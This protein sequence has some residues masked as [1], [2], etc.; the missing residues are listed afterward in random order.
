MSKSGISIRCKDD[1][2]RTCFTD[3]VKWESRFV[4]SFASIESQLF[5]ND[6]TPNLP[7]TEEENG[8]TSNCLVDRTIGSLFSTVIVALLCMMPSTLQGQVIINGTVTDAIGTGISGVDFDLAPVAG[9][10]SL[11]LSGDVSGING[12]FSITIL[13]GAGHSP[14]NPGMY[15]LQ[16]NPPPGFLSRTESVNLAIPITGGN[17]ALGQF[18]LGSGWVISGQLVDSF[19]VGIP[20]IDIDIQPDSGGATTPDISGD[21]SG[22]G[23][24]FSVTMQSLTSEYN[25][26]FFPPSPATTPT[27]CVGT[28][29]PTAN[30][31]CAFGVLPLQLPV[32]LISGSTNLGQ[33][34]L[35]NAA[36]VTAR[37][38]DSL[39][40]PIVGIDT[41]ALDAQGVTLFLNEDDSDCLGQI[42]IMLPLGTVDLFF[43][44]PLPELPAPQVITFAPVYLEGLN[45]NG[46]AN[47]GDFVMR[48]GRTVTGTVLRANGTP[49]ADAEIEI[50]D[51][52]TGAL[53]YEAADRT[54]TAGTFNHFV[55]DGDYTVEVDPPAILVTTVVP[56]RFP[57]TVAGGMVNM[58]ALTL[59]NGFQISGRCISAPGIPFG[60]VDVAFEQSSNGASVSALHENAGVDG[61]FAA[62]L[63]PN[64][65]DV[66]LY[67]PVGSG[68][69]AVRVPTILLNTQTNLGDLVLGVGVSF[70]GQVV[71]G[72]ALVEGAEVVA[73]GAINYD[74]VTDVGGNFGYQ[75]PPGTYNITVIPPLGSPDPVLTEPGVV[76]NT[77]TNRVFDL[78]SGPVA[79]FVRGDVNSSGSINL[80]DA[81]GIL[82]YLFSGGIIPCLDSAD[83]NDSGAVNLAD[84]IGILGFLFSGGAPPPP[85]FPNAGVDPTADSLGC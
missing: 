78:Q 68:R 32:M 35:P 1:R 59:Q 61:L 44:E 46:P 5:R 48:P 28:V 80:A 22:A 30:P 13:Q 79:T 10:T 23:G 77:D 84:A 55:P 70:T 51:A 62:T 54:T 4:R 73:Q 39:G 60:P 12:A 25:I 40:F 58:G 18:V 57:L 2:H 27:T 49:I 37:I 29:N 65:Y 83:Y 82:G 34:T 8:M 7:R 15:S 6:R 36:C 52:V 67:P 45:I 43:R 63:P 47:L 69:T 26:Q 24:F 81:I 3:L 20:G 53:A 14:Y 72:G 71:S 11:S 9:G 50:R 33:L 42:H 19:G 21:L 75:L 56:Q 16:M 64:T 31:N 17:Q 74:N 66:L 38:V 85:P 41:Q 76:I